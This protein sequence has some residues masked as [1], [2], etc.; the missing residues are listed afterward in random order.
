MSDGGIP[1][2]VESWLKDNTGIGVLWDRVDGLAMLCYTETCGDAM[3]KT[4]LWPH[5]RPP[6]LAE[7]IL[8]VAV[9][10]GRTG[11]LVQ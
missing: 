5:P 6:T 2:R 1:R 8:A 7:A 11:K 4:F 10:S 9:G 3:S